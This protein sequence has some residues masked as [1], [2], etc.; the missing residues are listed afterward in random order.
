MHVKVDGNITVELVSDAIKMFGSLGLKVHITELDVSCP[1]CS[2]GNSDA[3]KE[4]AQVYSNVVQ[5]CLDNKGVCTALLTW[6]FTD[7]YTWLGSDKYPLPFDYN[8]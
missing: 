6:G 3:L 5:A 8:F 4:Q 1:K 2:Q 7:R